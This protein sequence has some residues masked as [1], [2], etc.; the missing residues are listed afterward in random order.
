MLTDAE[1][2]QLAEPTLRGMLAGSGLETVTVGSGDDHHGDPSL[3]LDTYFE[4]R[5]RP[6]DVPALMAAVDQVRQQIE[7]RGET[8]FLYLRL[9]IPDRDED[10]A[11]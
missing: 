8:R 1:L 7:D 6:V 11:A 3:F 4:G 5:G 10:L 2:L 9:H